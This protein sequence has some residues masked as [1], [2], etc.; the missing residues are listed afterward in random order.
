VIDRFA[1]WS[2]ACLTM[3]GYGA[4]GD[5]DRRRLWL[6][7]RFAPALCLTGIALGT[8]LASPPL[9]FVMAGSAA[10]GGFVLPKHPFDYLYDAA[11]RP[12]LGG[13]EVPPSPPP[14]RFACQLATPWILAIA[15]A[16]LAGAATVAWVLAAPLLAA[17]AVVATTNWCMPSFI[18]GVVHSRDAGGAPV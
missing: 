5:G 1:T 2:R 10:L 17:G 13:P 18:Y 7:L 6:G 12:L 15:I 11:L 9:L 8:A 14:R 4:L 3:Q 16:L